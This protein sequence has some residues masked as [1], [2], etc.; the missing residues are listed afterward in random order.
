M[1]TTEP[2]ADPTTDY[3]IFAPDFVAD[4]YPVFDA[5]RSRC[6]VAHTERHQGSWMPTTYEALHDIAHDVDTFSS[7]DILVFPRPPM[8][9]GMPYHD[10]G[11]PPISSDPPVHK[12][13]RKLVLPFFAPGAVR[14]VRG[15]HPRALPPAHRRLHRRRVG[16]MSPPTTRSRSRCGSS[17]RCSAWTT[18]RSDEFVGLGARHPRAGPPRSRGAAR[19]PHRPARLLRGAGRRSPR[20][21]ARGRPDHRAR[22]GRGRRGAGAR[23]PHPRHVQPDAGGGDRHHLVG[24][25]VVPVALRA[26]PR[27]PPAA[28][29]RPGPVAQRHRGAA[30][31]LLARDHGPHRGAGHRVRRLPDEGGRPRAHAVPG[32]EPRPGR[33]RGP[34]RGPPR[35]RG[36]PAPGL[37]L[38]HPPLR[39]L[40]PRPPRAA[41]LAPGVPRAHPRLRARRPRRRD[42][43]G[44]SG[45]RAPHLRG[46]LRRSRRRDRRRRGPPRPQDQGGTA[47]GHGRARDRA[48]L[49]GDLD[50]R[51]RQP[52]RRRPAPPSTPTTRARRPC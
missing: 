10:V 7:S 46:A 21:P 51:P 33:V 30:A 20:Q 25:R 44:W 40:E 12:W 35:P 26:A 32:R 13:A 49:R 42:V 17:P 14:P 29:R 38:G 31:G 6:P 19:G 22:P 39:R 4:P 52:R 23:L 27:A 18:A 45:P 24:H 1:S 37:R 11:A 8:T 50:R 47:A 36:Q 48:G 9:D 2:I 16:P 34:R 3:D 15:G 41:G 28:P 43:G 5:I